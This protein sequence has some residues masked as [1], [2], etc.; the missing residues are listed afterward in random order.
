[1][2]AYL[3]QCYAGGSAITCKDKLETINED[4]LSLVSSQ[5]R[6]GM[7]SGPCQGMD[8]SRRPGST[9][10]Q[11]AV[12]EFDDKLELDCKRLIVVHGAG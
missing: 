1:M 9:E 5:L 11:T 3:V 8:W 7:I 4:N 12:D 10:I 6:Q 2:F